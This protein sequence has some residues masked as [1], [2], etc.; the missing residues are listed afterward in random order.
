MSFDTWIQLFNHHHNED[1]EKLGHSKEFSY[2]QSQ[3]RRHYPLPTAAPINLIYFF[4]VLPFPECHRNWNT[5]YL[6]SV[7]DCFHLTKC[8]QGLL[9]LLPGSV[10]VAF[11]YWVVS[12]CMDAPQ[13]VYPLIG[14]QTF[15]LF[16]IWGYYER[17]CYKHFHGGLDVHLCFISPGSGVDMNSFMLNFLFLLI[18]FFGCTGSSLR[19]VG[20][21]LWCL[22]FCR[23]QASVVETQAQ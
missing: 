13:F 3:S 6:V 7:S 15:R 18:H 19:F 2:L 12:H 10:V 8:S 1:I 4:I 22:L 14:G 21:S 20:F 17:I 23:A 16:W 11:Y 5:S 9:A